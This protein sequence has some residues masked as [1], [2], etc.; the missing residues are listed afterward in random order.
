MTAA[1][2][3]RIEALKEAA[4]L[5]SLA[6]QVA[7][8]VVAGRKS[9]KPLT[10][11]QKNSWAKITDC[12]VNVQMQSQAAFD[13]AECLARTWRS[14]CENGGIGYARLPLVGWLV[15]I[16]GFWGLLFEMLLE[17]AKL[18]IESKRKQQD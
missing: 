16:P 13:D 17:L 18:W 5:R 9:R 15:P 3:S 4:A 8:P 6:E 2:D 14:I 12:V 11:K 1:H 10:T 7:S